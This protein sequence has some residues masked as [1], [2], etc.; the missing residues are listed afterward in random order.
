MFLLFSRSFQLNSAF[1]SLFCFVSGHDFSRAV[2][3]Q[4]KTGFRVCRSSSVPTTNQGVPHISLV[5]REMWETTAA[6]LHS[7]APWDCQSRSVVSHISRL[8]QNYGL[9]PE[10]T[11]ESSPARSAGLPSR[12]TVTVTFRLSRG[13]T[14]ITAMPSP[15]WRQL[16]V[17]QLPVR[18]SEHIL[19][20]RQVEGREAHRM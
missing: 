18:P 17:T 8:R 9:S 3:A 2:K 7:S 4:K 19:H 6:D 16:A 20:L 14:R 10:G 1:C 15:L 12:I 5:F 13:S 11:S